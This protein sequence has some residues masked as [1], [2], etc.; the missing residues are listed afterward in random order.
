MARHRRT[1]EEQLADAAGQSRATAGIAF[2]TP[3]MVPITNEHLDSELAS[4]LE[5]LNTDLA[6]LGEDMALVDSKISEAINDANAIPITSDRFTEDSL[7][8]WP[9]IQGTVPQG[10]LAPG[11]VGTGDL[12][13]FVLTARKFKDDRHR[14][15]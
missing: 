6:V 14:L 9:F 11:A 4:N 7:S 8:I 3:P 15:Y 1:L 13:D 2:A 10:A 12:A 5:T